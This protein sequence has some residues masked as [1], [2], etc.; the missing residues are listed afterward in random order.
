MHS[1]KANS[2][3]KSW[4]SKRLMAREHHSPEWRGEKRQS[5]DWR[6]REHFRMQ[7]LAESSD[8]NAQDEDQQWELFGTI[9]T[10]IFRLSDFQEMRIAGHR[11]KFPQH[12][13]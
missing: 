9:G 4:T 3:F 12:F 1:G 8:C 6:S 7:M 13:D 5:G 10:T 11:G 2:K